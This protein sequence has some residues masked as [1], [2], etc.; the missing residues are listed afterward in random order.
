MSFDT[1]KAEQKAIE[2]AQAALDNPDKVDLEAEF[3][4]LLVAY[5]KLLKV[6]GRIVRMS[7]RSEERLKV[8]N[9]T[10]VRQQQEL[11]KAHGQLSEHAQQLENKVR[12]RTKELVAAQS[13]LEQLVH[14]GIA[15]SVERQHSKFME[16]IV[17][18]Q[19]HLTNA[20]GGILFSRDGDS[21]KY[22]TLRFDT[23]DLRLGGLSGNPLD[24]PS[25]PLRDAQGKP[26]Y[27][28]P[29]AQAVL[30]ERTIN[31]HNINE[32]KD[33]DFAELMQFDE[34]QDYHSQ[35]LLSG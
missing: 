17:E 3:R 15:L 12:D 29:V 28:N 30:T 11:E 7:D 20:D 24:Y 35:S 9:V 18:G 6:T 31:V 21:L 13:K 34:Q 16:M 26:N 4:E 22:E 10:I 2:R 25:I 8:A 5:I 19:K 27:F 33:F 14:L 1:F 23:L 32:C